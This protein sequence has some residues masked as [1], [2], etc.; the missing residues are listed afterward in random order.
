[1]QDRDEKSAWQ[2]R[3]QK[4][5]TGWDQ[6]G[7]HPSL[8][9]LIAHAE[10]EGGLKPEARIYSAGAGRAHSEAALADRGYRVRAV[11]LSSD[12]IEWA[13]THYADITSLELKTSDIFEIPDEEREAFD[14]IYDR[15]MLCALS[16]D[17]RPS[18]VSAM[19][20]RLKVGGLFC[21]IL[22]RAVE[23]E[24]SPPYP[25]D[26]VEA[27]RLFHPDFQLCYAA[28]VPAAP[29]PQAIKEE[30]ICVWRKKGHP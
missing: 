16:P 2:E 18:Y 3:W 4:G 7:P 27:M 26:E 10:R 24:K 17:V 23:V 25:V 30:W 12:A 14:A 5:R 29:E 13:K 19:K 15:A 1:M 11:D 8:S 22:F 6:G 28:A 21:G 20:A 9:R